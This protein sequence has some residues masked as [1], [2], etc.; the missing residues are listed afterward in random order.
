MR[1][2]CNGL[3]VKAL[4]SQ[5]RGLMF[6]TTGWLVGQLSH[7]SFWG[8]WVPGISGNLVVKS[9][10]PPWSGSRLEVVEPHPQKGAIKFQVFLKRGWSTPWCIKV[11]MLLTLKSALRKLHLR[12]Y[13]GKT[14]LVKGS[15]YEK[16]PFLPFLTQ[17]GLTFWHK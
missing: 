3:V 17:P 13:L 1:L 6:K 9:K 16:K 8:R 15:W 2:R 4:D 5:S 12:K 14:G 10:L 7:S 11:L